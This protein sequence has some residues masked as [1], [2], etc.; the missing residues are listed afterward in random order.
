MTLQETKSFF[1]SRNVK[2]D[3]KCVSTKRFVFH[4]V[5]AA[6]LLTYTWPI[7]NLWSPKRG[8]IANPPYI[9]IYI[10][11]IHSHTYLSCLDISSSYPVALLL[12]T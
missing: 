9:Y 5:N 1:E 6:T 10:S 7:I 8:H 2:V 12:L 3:K 11:Y 4:F